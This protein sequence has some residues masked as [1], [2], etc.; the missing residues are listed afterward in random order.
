MLVAEPGLMRRL[1]ADAG[2]LLTAFAANGNLEGTRMLLDLGLDPASVT[3]ANDPYNGILRGAT[4]LHAAA[5]KM[6]HNVVGLLLERGAPV[7]AR[8]A[9]GHSPLQLAVA[10]CVHSYWTESR[11]L[12]S[13]TMLV[14]AGAATGDIPI[15]TGY[16]EADEYLKQ[17]GA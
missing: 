15:P 10:A 12:T 7:E 13:I 6:S 2:D 1:R 11:S 4:A 5:W 8:T 3:G 9:K 17:H 14:E 16:A